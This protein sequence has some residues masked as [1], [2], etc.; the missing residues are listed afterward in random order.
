MN[1]AR[2]KTVAG[3]LRSILAEIKK[4][5][6]L[7]ANKIIH[8]K[9]SVLA[10]YQPVFDP[11]NIADL[12]EEEFKGFLL[13]R[14]N[15][16]WGALHRLGGKMTADMG[17]LRNALGVLL[18]ESRPIEDRLDYL[19]PKGRALVP[20]LGRAV[21]T[22]IL[23][24]KF[25]EKYGVWNNPSEAGMRALNVWPEFDSQSSFGLRYKLVNERILAVA[26]EMGIDLWTLDTLWWQAQAKNALPGEEDENTELPVVDEEGDY[27]FGLERHLH[28]FLRDNWAATQLNREWTILEQDGDQVGYEYPAGTIGSIDLLARHKTEPRWLVIE[29][30]RNQS[31]DATV[32]QILRY[33]GWAE[34]HLAKDGEK[35]EGMIIAHGKDEKIRYALKRVS[36]VRLMLYEVKFQLM[37]Q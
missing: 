2:I 36:D 12:T 24:V 28:D 7:E 37:E 35:V 22:A 11:E 31:S 10:R 13:F 33:M 23:Q 6:E 9:D 30:K 15:Q 26:A 34:E 20:C 17:A 8:A 16:H 18:D 14:N 5:P 21:L 29:L 32:G 19:V 3:Q 1:D 27:R 4:R 25:P